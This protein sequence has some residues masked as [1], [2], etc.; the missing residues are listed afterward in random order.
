MN[1]TNVKI[2]KVNNGKK[3]EA[4]A[5]VTIDNAIKIQG[6]KIVAGEKGY[7]V[8]MPSRPD[9]DGQYHDT[10][11]P[12]T[13]GARKELIESVLD[14][15]TKER[16]ER[17]PAGR[18]ECASKTPA[19]AEKGSIK[20]QLAEISRSAKAQPAKAVKAPTLKKEEVSL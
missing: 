14:A 7:F 9:K 18:E 4:M 8:A 2:S 10:V 16:L 1:I 5:S 12:I 19:A 11:Y 13:A 17:E 6:F 15:F 3:L 20:E